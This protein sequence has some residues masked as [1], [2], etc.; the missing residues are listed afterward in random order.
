MISICDP[1]MAQRSVQG[2]TPPSPDEVVKDDEWMS[3]WC[4]HLLHRAAVFAVVDFGDC[5]LLQLSDCF[6]EWRESQLQTPQLWVPQ[7]WLFLSEWHFES[8]TSFPSASV[9]TKPSSL[10]EDDFICCCCRLLTVHSLFK[11]KKKKN[12]GMNYSQWLRRRTREFF[13]LEVHTCS[14]SSDDHYLHH[15][16]RGIFQ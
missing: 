2:V 7:D 3:E 12:S 9:E 8:H 13:P 6:I 10:P 16:S 4:G 14:S 15:M 11:G 1:V 5:S